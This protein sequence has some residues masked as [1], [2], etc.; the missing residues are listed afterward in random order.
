M[1]DNISIKDGSGADV[2]VASDDISSVQYPRHKLVWGADGAVNDTSA[3]APLPA[4]V[5]GYL[6]NPTS[7]LT[8]PADAN[9]YAALD[10]IANNTTGAS[11]T[12]PSLTVARVATGSLIIRRVRLVTNHTTSFDAVVLRVR[13]WTAAPT[14]TNGDNAAY[15]LAGGAANFLGQFD[16]TMV[17][18][19]DGAVGVGVPSVG[20]EVGIKLASGSSVYWDLQVTSGTPTPASGKTFILTAETYQN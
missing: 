1:A 14:Y 11:V 16:I 4:I 10:M 19:A 17:Q 3:T 18:H 2:T 6:E 8:R 7:T 13:L 20:G 5:T 12:V 15:L 9:I